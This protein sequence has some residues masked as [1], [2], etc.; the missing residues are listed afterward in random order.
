MIDLNDPMWPIVFLY[1]IFA[2]AFIG[3]ILLCSAGD[4]EYRDSFREALNAAGRLDKM[5]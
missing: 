5:R 2:I 4:K 1:A 3:A